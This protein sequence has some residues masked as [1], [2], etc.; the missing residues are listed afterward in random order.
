MLI[1]RKTIRFDITH[2]ISYLKIIKHI[3]AHGN[4]R[5]LILFWH[6]SWITHNVSDI[7]Q[8]LQTL[9]E[10][11]KFSTIFLFEID[12][13]Q[14]FCENIL[15]NWNFSDIVSYY[16]DFLA[17]QRI[18]K[19]FIWFYLVEIR[20]FHVI[21]RFFKAW[22]NFLPTYK[23]IYFLLFHLNV[24]KPS[25]SRLLSTIRWMENKSLCLVLMVNQNIDHKMVYIENIYVYHRKLYKQIWKFVFRDKTRC[26]YEILFNIWMNWFVFRKSHKTWTFEIFLHSSNS[27]FRIFSSL[28]MKLL[29]FFLAFSV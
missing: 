16:S 14:I 25:V 13:Y 2:G 20:G 4:D 3:R 17:N 11:S 9:R 1:P 19:W 15:I 21:H 28:D 12:K 7:L 24:S 29:P 8:V 23:Y 26:L 10:I 22:A 5:N 18:W 27:F 6:K